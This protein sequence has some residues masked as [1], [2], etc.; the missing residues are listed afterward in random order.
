MPGMRAPKITVT[1]D[2]GVERKV[3]YG[4]SY[5][6][7]CGRQWS[8]AQ[9]PQADYEAIRRLDRRYRLIGYSLAIVFAGIC[10]FVGLTRPLTLLVLVPSIMLAW[11]S[12][13]RPSVRRRHYRRV[14][15]LTRQW[16]L[17]ADQ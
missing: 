9:I 1:C 5:T 6:C 3:A 7:E 17:R 14:H 10:L 16:K 2:C 8:T 11:F 15:E 13:V 4:E 12:F